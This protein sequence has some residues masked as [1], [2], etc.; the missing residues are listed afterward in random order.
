MKQIDVLCK[1]VLDALTHRVKTATHHL[2]RHLVL[3]IV[4]WLHVYNKQYTYMKRDWDTR[5]LIITPLNQR[6]KIPNL[7]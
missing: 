6:L 3:R 5:K 7:L 2:Y 4:A 1:V